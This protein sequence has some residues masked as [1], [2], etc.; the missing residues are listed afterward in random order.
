M[1]DCLVLWGAWR[2]GD[3]QAF[4]DLHA[5]FAGFFGHLSRSIARGIDRDDVRAE[6]TIG[7][8]IA[9]SKYNPSK[10]ALTPYVK[11]WALAMVNDFVAKERSLGMMARH[12]D[13]ELFKAQR[14]FDGVNVNNVE[15]LVD[16][17]VSEEGARR[18]MGR[19]LLLAQIADDVADDDEQVGVVLAS[20]WPNPEEATA[21]EQSKAVMLAE[22][23]RA[24][25][26]LTPTQEQ[27]IRGMLAGEKTSDMAERRGVTESAVKSN[28]ATAK[29]ALRRVMLTSRSVCEIV[30]GSK[31]QT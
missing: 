8:L 9:L 19:R 2:S 21:Q 23:E 28:Y 22:L 30:D 25:R 31:H 15:S 17:G 18:Y 26:T 13:G 16:A 11:Q 6:A 27:T 14:L 3:N 1:D 24:I 5:R 10:G 29:A 12:S 20:E 4:V 7:M